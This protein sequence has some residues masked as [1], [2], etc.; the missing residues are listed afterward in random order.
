MVVWYRI[1]DPRNRPWKW[2]EKIWYDW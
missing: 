2:S 1:H